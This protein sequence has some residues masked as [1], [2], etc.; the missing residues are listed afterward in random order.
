MVHF[1]FI[2]SIDVAVNERLRGAADGVSRDIVAGLEGF[3][4]SLV[5][6][7]GCVSGGLNSRLLCCYVDET[8]GRRKWG[9]C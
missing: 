7:K 3:E 4:S 5:D 2:L 8:S 9:I 1:I 6:A